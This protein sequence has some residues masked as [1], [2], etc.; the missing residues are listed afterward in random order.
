MAKQVVDHQESIFHSSA[1]S[2]TVRENALKKEE[3]KVNHRVISI[4]WLAAAM[5]AFHRG[6]PVCLT[7]PLAAFLI[8]GVVLREKPVLEEVAFRLQRNSWL[9]PL[10]VCGSIGQVGKAAVDTEKPLPVTNNNI[11]DSLTDRNCGA[12]LERQLT[13]VLLRC[14]G[15]PCAQLLTW[16]KM[17]HS[18][19]LG[20]AG[21]GGAHFYPSSQ[22]A[23]A[24][25]SLWVRGYPSSHRPTRNI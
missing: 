5:D 13:S 20:I 2:T 14:V 3:L 16:D 25:K 19:K 8:S 17:E 15:Q 11:T 21:H 18:I 1:L 23:D 6:M 10:G 4:M 24:G 7:W 12:T 9:Q 22:E